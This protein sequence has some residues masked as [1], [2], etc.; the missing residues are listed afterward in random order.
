MESKKLTELTEEE[1][2]KK[3]K[4]KKEELKALRFAIG[5]LIGAAIISAV[6]NGFGTSTILPICFI[7]IIFSMRKKLKEVEVEIE[8]RKPQ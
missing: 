4:K 5:V 8:S 3:E 6:V 7:P 2:K 1:L